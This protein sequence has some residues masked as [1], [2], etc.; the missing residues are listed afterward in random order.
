MVEQTCQD[1]FANIIIHVLQSEFAITLKNTTFNH[2]SVKR[3]LMHGHKVHFLLLK[4]VSFKGKS[5]L[6]SKCHP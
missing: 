5:C 6:G 3:V 2:R 4:G 1:P